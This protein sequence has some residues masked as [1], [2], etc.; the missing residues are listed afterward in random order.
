MRNTADKVRCVKPLKIYWKPQQKAPAKKIPPEKS[1]QKT[2]RQKILTRKS[3]SKLTIVDTTSLFSKRKSNEL[4]QSHAMKH[5]NPVTLPQTNSVA[6][7]LLSHTILLFAPYQVSYKNILKSFRLP[8]DA[9]TSFKRHLVAFRRTD[10]LS[11]ILV[12]SKLRTDK[13]TDVT[14]DPFDAAKIALPVAIYITDGRTNYTFSA[15]G[16][17]RTIHDHIDC[18]SKNLIFMIHCLRC[19]KQDIGET[20]RRLKDHFNEYRRPVDRP[21]PSS[22]PTAVSDHFL[23]DNHSPNDIELIPL[24]LIHSSRD[25]LRKAREDRVK[26]TLSKGVKLLNPKV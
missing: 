25:A 4:T 17:I 6:F 26:R 7:R 19:N 13:Q 11:D 14:R 16:E 2:F 22:R 20:K 18:N 23:S 24:E 12:R 5:S 1:R 8:H 9:T 15:T 21:I 3:N 10:N